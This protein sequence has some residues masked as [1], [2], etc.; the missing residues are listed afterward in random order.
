[1]T[2]T[3][4]TLKYEMSGAGGV[5]G[6]NPFKAKA[7]FE[8]IQNWKLVDKL[9]KIQEFMFTLPNDEFSR[10]NAFVERKAFI[11][12]IKPFNGFVTSKEQD[13]TTI[14]LLIKE[15]ATHLERRKTS[16]DTLKR[17]CFT[18]DEWFDGEW[19][20]RAKI[21]INHKKV[22][23]DIK[24]FPVLVSISTSVPIKRNALSSGN[25]ILF[26]A[27]DGVTKIPHEIEK[28]DSQ[29]GEL[30]AH[31]KVS[32]INDTSNAFFYIY[33]GNPNATDQQDIVNVWK[34]TNKLGTGTSEV[35]HDYA[36]IQHLNEDPTDTPPEYKDSTENNNDGT[37][38]NVTK[39]TGKIGQAA[40]FDGVDSQI[41]CGSGTTIDDLFD[42]GGWVIGWIEPDSDG[43]GNAGDIFNKG[44]KWVV[45]GISEA[46]GLLVLRFVYDFDGA[47]NGVWQTAVNIPINKKTFF[48]IY[49]DNGAVGNDPTFFI[50]NEKRTVANGL[51]T[52][53]TTPIGTRVSD[54][55]DVLKIGNNPI[56]SQTFDGTIDEVRLATV[57]PPN[58]D[59]LVKTIF[60]NQNDPSAFVTVLPQ[61]QYVAKS[62]DVVQQILD[63]AN[64]DQEI[65]ETT[66]IQGLVSHI[67]FEHDMLDAFAS[68][69]GTLGAGTEQ[70]VRGKVGRFAFDFNGSTYINVANEGNFDT[71]LTAKFSVS[72]WMKHT[73]GAVNGAIITKATS[74]AFDAGWG[75]WSHSGSQQVRLDI[76]NGTQE[77]VIRDSA[78]RNDGLYHHYIFTYDGSSTRAGMSLYVDG[79]K[80]TPNLEG[81]ASMTGSM[82]N[83]NA[84][85]IGAWS[86]GTVILPSD[87][88]EDEVRFYKDK[89]LTQAEV[90]ALFNANNTNSNPVQKQVLWTLD[91]DVPG[92]TP[93]EGLVSSFDFE[94]NV[95]DQFASNDGTITGSELYVTGKLGKAFDFDGFSSVALANEANF[96]F[97]NNTKFSVNYWFKSTVGGVV[98][99]VSKNNATNGWGCFLNVGSPELDLRNT[100]TTDELRV[101]TT[102][103][104]N[105]GKYHHV[106]ITYSGLLTPASII[107]YVDKVKVALTTVTDTLSSTIL[108]ALPVTIG[109]FNA[110]TLPY[111][112]EIDEV[113]IYKDKVLNQEEVDRLFEE[114]N[115]QFKGDFDHKNHFEA[116]QI[117]GEHLG[118]DVWFDNI[119][120]VVR[121]G[122]KGKT[123]SDVL[124]I[125]ITS[126]PQLNTEDFA[127]SIN[128]IGADREEGDKLE[129]ISQSSTPLRFNYEKTIADDQLAQ[130]EQLTQ[131]GDNLLKEFEKLTP[132]IKGEVPTH[133]FN[134]LNLE[135]GD[136]V[137][138][139]QP[140]RQVIGDFR[141]MDIKVN[142]QKAKL[143]LESTE[144]GVI[145]V[146]SK[147]FSDTIEGILKRINDSSL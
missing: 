123:L 109:A 143:S 46:S 141:I 127:N 5:V 39:V 40:D 1:M 97:E 121:V 29:T 113:K 9:N 116:L 79:I 81:V 118:D 132:Q 106:V 135:S 104:F 54:A 82:L 62:S 124:D 134:R 70:Y 86:G 64:D 66:D 103:K 89:E 95:L 6:Q 13:K 24:E 122:T 100:V 67:P 138:I 11:P 115:S 58:I 136:I 107:I 21:I 78:T 30:I 73:F 65:L 87:T 2:T 77:M 57:I 145:R 16:I 120:H 60:N 90:T 23:D 41:D 59:A 8:Q 12:F 101:R 91:Q 35:T 69:N 31:V 27:K 42:S 129:S 125:I 117:V 33:Y 20:Y 80:I 130:D 139:I 133:Q 114:G 119:E 52:E 44:D 15:Y 56:Q 111:T 105:D 51:L 53:T 22:A 43:E 142:S 76:Q 75:I 108:N 85:T 28:Y 14:T 140:E 17:I 146:R 37:E 99:L 45:D 55:V 26:T 38:T 96:D 71:E 47:A 144:T 112:G 137:K 92:L 83:N 4:S 63:S 48:A 50:N 19:K 25:D 98:G 94:D 128:I 18:N 126:K 147:S 131:V 34:A 7:C 102:D 49:Y 110:L 84:V 68:N 36:M 93:T 32:K 72:F 88:K 10:A 74:G 61:E 3:T